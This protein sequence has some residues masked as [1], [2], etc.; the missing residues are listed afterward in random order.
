MEHPILVIE[1]LLKMKIG[2]KGRLLYLRNYIKKGKPLYDSDK[3]FLNRMQIELEQRTSESF[4]D[5]FQN[6]SSESSMNTSSDLLES[7]NRNFSESISTE[8][9]V[10]SS[11]GNSEISKIQNLMDK[12]KKSE[13]RLA[14]NYELLLISRENLPKQ[15][16]EISNSIESSSDI[17]KNTVDVSS[18]LKNNLEQKPSKSFKI[19]K[20]DLMA[21][22]SAGL[23]TLWY[24]SF[25]N[26]IDLGPFQN[27]TLGLSAGAV[28]ATIMFYRQQKKSS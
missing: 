5:S 20:H 4:D 12:L 1:N 3:K 8:K 2:D 28:A 27:I 19:K 7:S 17:S 14:D 16:I 11:K 21:Y 15:K 10:Q 24:A 22:A 23:F 13:S 26:M 18:L 9:K 6:N 25:Q